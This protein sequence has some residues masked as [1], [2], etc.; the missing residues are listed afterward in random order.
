MFK[1]FDRVNRKQKHQYFNQKGC[2]INSSVSPIHST[3]QSIVLNNQL[4]YVVNEF[5]F[6][7]Y[8]VLSAITAVAFADDIRNWRMFWRNKEISRFRYYLRL[9]EGFVTLPLNVL[10][11]LASVLYMEKVSRSQPWA[12]L[13]S[14]QSFRKFLLE[15]EFFK[16][17]DLKV[18]VNGAF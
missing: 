5:D 8:V 13:P 15:K 2:W 14:A 10:V 11:E 12:A 9:M 16:W 6:S 18:L 4:E 3:R 7:I 17:R 1:S